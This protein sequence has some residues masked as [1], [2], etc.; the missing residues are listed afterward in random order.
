M[1]NNPFFYYIFAQ[2][3]LIFILLCKTKMLKILGTFNFPLKKFRQVYCTKGR[4]YISISSYP[5]NRL[6]LL[7]PKRFYVRRFAIFLSSI[8]IE[9]YRVS[10]NRCL[11]YLSFSG[12]K[13]F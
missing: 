13:S 10:R 9:H 4:V 2:S 3:S 1:G 12:V 6:V 5:K 11:V 8:G 7:F